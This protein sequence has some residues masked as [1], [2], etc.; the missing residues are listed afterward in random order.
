LCIDACDKIM[1]RM[2][3][4][5]G[6]IKFSTQNGMTN[7]WSSAQIK[8][9]I[10]RPRVLIYAG[11]LIAICLAFALSLGMKSSFTVNVIR[12]RG[13]MSRLVAGGNIE[14]VYR[15]SIANATEKK[16]TYRVSV[17]GIDDLIVDS[18]NTFTV[19]PAAKRVFPIS[20]QLPDRAIENGSH[21]IYFDIE[22]VSTSEHIKER[23][24]FF[25]PR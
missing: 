8:Q 11:V 25:M 24:I 7:K 6:L 14:N 20:L 3:Y 10:L 13:V 21:K 17:E 18:N 1:D 5:R 23:S 22:S 12:D 4:P 19:A 9:K 15:L 16:E 2:E